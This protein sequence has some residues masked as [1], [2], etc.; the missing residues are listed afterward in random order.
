MNKTI[1]VSFQHLKL[2]AWNDI[3]PLYVYSES[4]RY[5]YSRRAS[6]GAMT[7]WTIAPKTVVTMAI[8]KTVFVIESLSHPNSVISR[9]KLTQTNVYDPRSR[10]WRRIILM[11][12]NILLLFVV[13]L[14]VV[15][16]FIYLLFVCVKFYCCWYCC[17]CCC[18]LKKGK[19]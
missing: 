1:L 15:V 16:L 2:K 9:N 19:S 7:N 5:T 8:I 10:K 12:V 6:I 13:V 4:L 11:L 18:Y 3:L 14:L 17:S